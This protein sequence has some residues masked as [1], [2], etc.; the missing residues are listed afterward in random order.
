VIISQ[1]T[2]KKG[3]ENLKIWREIENGRVIEGENFKIKTVVENNKWL[4]ISFL[5]L[6][7]K[8]PLELQYDG[9]ANCYKEGAVL[10]HVS[11][12]SMFNY[13]RRKRTYTIKAVKR[14]TY[15]ISNMKLTIGDIFAFSSETRE[16]LDYKE[17]LVYPKIE[18]LKHYIFNPIN[19]SGDNIIKRWIYKD[20]LYIKGIREYS[21]EDRMK[22]IH[23]KSSLKMNKLMVKEYDYTSERELIIIVNVQCSELHWRYIQEKPIEDAIRVA[24]SLAVNSLKEGIPTGMW[25]NAEIISMISN[26]SREVKPALNSINRIMELCARMDYTTDIYFHKYLMQKKKE[27]NNN[28]TYVVITPYL[29]SESIHVL[30]KLSRAG[31]DFKMIDVSP[32]CNVPK[33]SGMEKIDYKGEAV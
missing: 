23:W 24:A 10:Y 29:N 5:L 31:Y 16:L 12:Y 20:L 2:R 8:M 13:E 22:D 28:C 11:R 33:V 32:K 17:L 15:I 30:S 19:L 9:E 3:F 6:R 14:G 18:N 4:P 7:E 21:V 25:T 27:L 1:I 26:Y